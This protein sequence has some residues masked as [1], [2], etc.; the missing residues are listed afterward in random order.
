MYNRIDIFVS[1]T[2][3]QNVRLFLLFFLRLKLCYY[4]SHTSERVTCV[5]GDLICPSMTTSQKNYALD[6]Y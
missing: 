6:K 1:L 3:R 2:R 4:D 5:G